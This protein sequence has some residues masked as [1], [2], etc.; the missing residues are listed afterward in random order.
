MRIAHQSVFS[1]VRH[2]FVIHILSP[3]PF[4]IKDN[5][6]LFD[7]IGKMTYC[8]N[9]II[10]KVIIE[11]L[12]HF[13]NVLCLTLWRDEQNTPNNKTDKQKYS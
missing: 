10:H 6:V 1:K 7:R 11:L 4:I 9:Q 3:S 2:I 8:N 12:R 5:K 13:L